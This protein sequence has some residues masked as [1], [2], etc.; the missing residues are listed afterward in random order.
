MPFQFVSVSKDNILAK[1]S[2]NLYRSLLNKLSTYGYESV[3]S[4]ITQPT[5]VIKTIEELYHS[6]T[7]REK[8]VMVSAIFYILCDTDYIKTPNPYYAYFGTLK[9]PTYTEQNESSE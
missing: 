6:K 5:E 8:R 1:S 2:R 4:L 9:E 3:S 7:K